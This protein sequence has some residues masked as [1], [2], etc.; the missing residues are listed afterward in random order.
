MPTLSDV[1]K[2]ALARPETA[3]AVETHAARYRGGPVADAEG[4]AR[5]YDL[6]TDFYEYGWGQSFHFAPRVVGE[7]LAA[8]ITRL[9]HTVAHRLSVG[10]GDAV[11]D[12]GC[13]VGG[14]MRTIAR[15]TG[16]RVTGVTI[17]DYQVSKANAHNERAGLAGQCEAVQG[18]FHALPAADDSFDAG[19]SFEAICHSDQRAKVL[20][21]LRRVVRPG[22]V[23]AG[24][25]WCLTSG[26]DARNPEHV[27]IARGVEEG[28]G[29]AP[30]ISLFAFEKAFEEAGLELLLLEDLAVPS[31]GSVPWYR[32]LQAGWRTP[33]E[34][35]RT[36][37]GRALTHGMVTALEAVGLAPEGTRETSAMLNRAA[38]HLIEGGRA[39]IFTPLAFFVARVH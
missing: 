6:V 37:L 27:R 14:P 5:Y 21:E 8:S 26:F 29:L 18:D 15:H 36:T 30:L 9:E 33:T 23:V 24:T 31:P 38:D 35:R 12:A 16:A 39:G 7:G 13:G 28:N 11:I 19:Y 3:S 17:N 1:T 10:P 20:A 25:D 34:L 22:G 2:G 32:A 4:A